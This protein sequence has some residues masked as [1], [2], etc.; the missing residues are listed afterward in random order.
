[1]TQ[2]MSNR[3]RDQE[4]VRVGDCLG[5]SIPFHSGVFPF[6]KV[7]SPTSIPP[8]TP[9]PTSTPNSTS[10]QSDPDYNC[11]P[12]TQT[13]SPPPTPPWMTMYTTLRSTPVFSRDT[14]ETLPRRSE[15]LI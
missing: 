8:P 15:A 4:G 14:R 3:D 10:S 6:L 11:R 5:T 13:W 9:T 7:P 12:S 2:N 1:M